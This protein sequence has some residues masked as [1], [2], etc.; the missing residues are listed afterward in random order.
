MIQSKTF[1][2]TGKK[3]ISWL[4]EVEY[5]NLFHSSEADLAYLVTL[6]VNF[7]SI[8]NNAPDIDSLFKHVA[9]IF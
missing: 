9:G 2:C 8:K 1:W 6:R 5:R 3:N 4:P 7:L